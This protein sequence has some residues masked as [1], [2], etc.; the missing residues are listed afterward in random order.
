MT[1]CGG[2]RLFFGPDISR[3]S[4]ALNTDNLSIDFT[5]KL[6]LG[7]LSLRLIAGYSKVDTYNLF[8]QRSLG[9]FYFDSLADYRNR[10]ANRLRYANAVPSNDPD[11]ASATFSTTGWNFGIQGDWDV[12]DTFQLTAG[13]R[14]DLF[15]NDA[16]PPL[17]TNFLARYGYS[18][19]STTSRACCCS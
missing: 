3:Q 5:G 6:D 1:G 8:L 4:N 10:R 11:D 13:V 2:T 17:N 19:R 9:D 15:D 12:S 7:Q 16:A 18:N 14:Y